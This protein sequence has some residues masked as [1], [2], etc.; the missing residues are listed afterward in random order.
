MELMSHITEGTTG[1]DLW[2]AKDDS[3]DTLERF[4]DQESKDLCC[5]LGYINSLLYEP[6]E[7]TSLLWA[8]VSSMV[9]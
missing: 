9:K 7:V 6:G 3:K 2:S 8:S 4:M 1:P 5:C